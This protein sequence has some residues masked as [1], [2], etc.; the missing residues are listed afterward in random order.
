MK[1]LVIVKSKKKGNT[2]QIAEVLAEVAPITITELENV[3]CYKI[4]EYDIIG[5]GSGIFL[6]K[7]YKELI[8]FASTVKNK[9]CF[10]FSTSGYNNLNKVNS[11]LIKL[12]EDNGNTVFGSFACRGV[13]FSKNKGHPNIDDFDSAQKF[14]GEVIEKYKQV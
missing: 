4:E 12:L 6:G 14:I 2:M 3:N 9:N 10:V 7:H 8:T 11:A 5:L 13:F 1:I